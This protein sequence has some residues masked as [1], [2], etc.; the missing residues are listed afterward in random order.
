ML[1]LYG[2]LCDWK[3]PSTV[4]TI[5]DESLQKNKTL[6]FSVFLIFEMTEHQINN[7]SIVFSLPYT[8]IM[9]SWRLSVF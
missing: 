3:R 2:Q 1:A 5:L 6:P 4:Q 7:G 9:D 8:F